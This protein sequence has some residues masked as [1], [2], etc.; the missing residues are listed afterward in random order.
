MKRN[1]DNLFWGIALILAAVAFLAQDLGYIDFN[2]LS[3]NHWTWVSA[4]IGAL[5]LLGYLLS[6]LKK[7]G[8][9]F[10]ACIMVSLAVIITLSDKG[11]ADAFLGSLIFIAIA[12]PFLVAF[13][14]NVRSN[15][16]ALIPAFSCLVLAAMIY[17]A[18]TGADE[19]IGALFMYGVGIPFLLVYF[20]NKDRRWALIPGFILVGIGTIAL[21]SAMSG[22]VNIIVTLV[23]AAIF[24]Y[25]YFTNSGSWWA[26][27]PAGLLASIGLN[28]ILILPFLGEFAKTSIPT[29]L[30]FLGWATTFYY[31]WTQRTKMPTEWAGIPAI[32]FVI[33]AI[34]QI[35]L[36]AINETGM[37]VLLFVG[38]I[39]LV[40]FGLQPKKSTD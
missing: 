5:F 15:W 31:L 30:M 37:I 24:F 6:G 3:T 16:W 9:L 36:G 21:A 13:L 10:P 28:S 20:F 8:Y 7:W 39:L 14:T 4:G 26:V 40:Y 12:I 34:V 2:A 35:V 1:T 23:L 11:I 38:G 22:W 25:V 17:F 33:V 18:D 29:G 19:W 32:V 27:I